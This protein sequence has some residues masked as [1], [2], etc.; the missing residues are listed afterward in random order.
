MVVKFIA[1][2]ITYAV[3]PF[4]FIF[5]RKKKRYAFGSFKGAFN[6]N[7]KYL[8]LYACEHC[9]DRDVAWL[10]VSGS[11][12]R[13]VR[14]LG[15]KAYRVTSLKGVWYALTAK[16][17]F[18]NAYTSDIMF[19]LSGGAVCCN[20]WHGVGIK[21]IEYNITSGQLARRYQ[22]KDLLDVFFHPQVFRKP[23]YILSSTPFQTHFFST[24]FRV[25][26]ERC[27]ELGYPRNEILVCP[28]EERAAFVKKYLGRDTLALLERMRAANRVY[29]YMP[30]WRDSQRT[31]F[32]QAMDL[33][34]L[35]GILRKNG[36]LLLLKPH[37]NVRA[38]GAVADA[39]T[40]ILF[41]GGGVD[42]YP[43]LPYTDVLVTDYSSVLYDY[44]LLPDRGILLYL[45]DYADYVAT[46]DFYYPFDENVVGRR[47][48]DFESLADAVGRHD[49]RVDE[50]RRRC[51]VEKFWGDTM[52][53][54]PSRRLLSMLGG[55]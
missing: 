43:L 12:V 31:L 40:N 50:G 17:W 51:L 18:F 46:R 4:S 52:R 42:V 54:G 41:V 6:D 15:L 9:R 53:Q 22:K 14:S 49:D 25:R 16:Y 8:F 44:L 34:R 10:S 32:A 1:Y 21:R 5:I 29:I 19:C 20:L 35:D 45:Y 11:T 33:E 48:Y 38:D 13:H 3:Y 2:L 55:E 47:V 28:E 26:P 23:D 36:D 39:L 7:A 24:S 30:T 37:A 27:W